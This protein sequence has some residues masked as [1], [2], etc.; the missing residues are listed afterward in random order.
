MR[1]TVERDQ[2]GQQ[3]SAAG[4][5]VLTMWG[6][7]TRLSLS[8]DASSGGCF[9]RSILRESSDDIGK[10]EERSARWLSAVASTK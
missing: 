10:M 4:V 6:G 3:Y 2:T 8:H 1:G 5:V 7:G 9:G